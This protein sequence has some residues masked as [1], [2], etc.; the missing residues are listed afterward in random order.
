MPNALGF[1][2]SVKVTSDLQPGDTIPGTTQSFAITGSCVL[3]KGSPSTIQVGSGIVA[4]TLNGGSVEVMPGVYSTPVPGIGIRLRDGSGNPVTNAG[5]Q[6]CHS[7]ISTIGSGGSY[8]FSG[9]LE[10]VRISGTI[11]QNATL[12]GGPTGNGAFAFG[13]YNTGTVLNDDKGGINTG[14][15][16][17]YPT[18]NIVFQNITCTTDY[19]LA[20]TLPAA[21]VADLPA[22]GST[23]GTTRFDIGVIC[24]SNAV[25]S[26]SMGPAAGIS[27]IN[28]GAG[29]VGLQNN[30][31]SASGVGI[32]ILDQNRNPFSMVS[33]N[34]LG[35]VSANLRSAF[36][37]F[38]RYN[39]VSSL[40]PGSVTSAVVFT[41]SYQ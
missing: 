1:P 30:A 13:V 17:I 11:P 36:P 27:A 31:G 41:M 12:S 8:A 32:Q 19:P 18:G 6:G 34:S 29:I 38:A 9:S 15:S 21:S 14:N 5:G 3:G 22:V 20:V 23:S 35:S 33:F 40:S 24:D 25:A 28:P 2:G 10:L 7:T 4:C 16:S 39:R 37:F 26:I